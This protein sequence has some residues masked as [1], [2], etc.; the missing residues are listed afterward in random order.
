MRDYIKRRWRD[1]LLVVLLIN[2]VFNIP[3]FADIMRIR[4]F[5]D[6]VET[7]TAAVSLYVDAGS[8][9][10]DNDGSS[11][12]PKET[13]QG[14][15]D[16]LPTT[17]AH[18]CTI[19]VRDGTYAE[20]NASITFARFNTLT[21]IYIRA[22]NSNDELMYDNGKATGGGNDDLDDTG[23]SWSADQFNG[24]Y[25]WI[26]EGTGRGQI[27]E[28]LD[29][30]SNRI[31]ISTGATNWAVNPDSTSYYAIGGGVTCSSTAS[32]HFQIAG[33][34]V[35]IY[36]FQHTGSTSTAM[37][38]LTYGVGRCYNNYIPNVPDGGLGGVMV[39][40]YSD[41]IAYY[42]YVG[43]TG[44]STQYGYRSMQASAWFR[45]CM[46][47]GDDVGCYGI[48]IERTGLC[49]SVSNAGLKNYLED[50]LVGIQVKEGS[51]C[52]AI[53]SQQYVSCPTTYSVDATSWNT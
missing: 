41:V 29:T 52:M 14:A 1:I 48:S 6:Y 16:A 43:L 20:D 27:R 38:W 25:I 32:H 37:Y 30:E 12:S 23:Q 13:I 4:P 7:T 11:G 47:I 28:I 9:D 33:K 39:Q 44:S 26:Y 18:D 10:D 5:G 53:A 45:A 35:G 51:G 19:Y 46:A 8:G 42:N 2:L 22:V 36:G 34:M 21:W 17:I 49:Q 31:V 40:S 15:L 3:A 50:C 24:A